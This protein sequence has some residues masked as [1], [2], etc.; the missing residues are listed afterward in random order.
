[1]KKII[2]FTLTLVSF[3][4][5]AQDDARII[6]RLTDGIRAD[7]TALVQKQTGLPAIDAINTKYGCTGIKKLNSGKRAKREL[8]VVTFPQ[9]VDRISLFGELRNTG[10]IQYVETDAI[11]TAGGLKAT[12]SSPNDALYSRQW[13][14][15]NDATFN[16]YPATSGAD[17]DMENA[18]AIEDGSSDIIVATMDSG[19]R[20]TH[21][22]FEGRLWTNTLEIPDNGIDDDDNGYIDDIN[23]W[24]FCVDDN[25]PTDDHGHGTN[26]T[27]IIAANG[28]NGEGY[29]GVDRHCKLMTLKGINSSNQGFYTWWHDGIIYAT[30]NGAN[31]INLSVGGNTYSATLKEAIDYAV[32]NGVVVVA[33]MM[34]TNT[35]EPYYPAKYD[36]VIAVGATNPDDKRTQPFFW[37]PNSGSNYGSHISVIAPG[38]F[39]YGLSYVSDTDYESYWGGTSQATPAVAGIASL[40]LAQDPSRTPA[41]IKAII[42][43]TAE[44]QVGDITED[45]AGFDIYYGHGRVNAFNALSELLSVEEHAKRNN[46]V[47]YPNPS[48]GI[49]NI[50]IDQYPAEVAVHN[51]LGQLILK[52]EIESGENAITIREKGLFLI[53]VKNIS[54]SDIRKVIIK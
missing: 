28:N 52:K 14:L 26:V 44:D 19:L 25:D 23:G 9:N 10:I 41:Q 3:G 8:F 54:G 1:M 12:T 45:I 15:H 37:D 48:E 50:D 53:T 7:K 22:E 24:D 27:G 18:W 47:V 35:D 42:E 36:G 30:D 43:A 32:E 4:L 31:V 38:N 17:I 33:C 49:V 29:S 16:M 40:L 6:I 11:G 46:L 2:L 5:Y 39:I 51:L 34:N 20:L 21:P 13:G